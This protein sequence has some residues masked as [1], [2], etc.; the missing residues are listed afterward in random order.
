M[1]WPSI[2]A[3]VTA[4]AFVAL[5]FVLY[6]INGKEKGNLKLILEGLIGVGGNGGLLFIIDTYIP[7]ADDSVR[8]IGLACCFTSFLV[9]VALLLAIF[10]HIIK[11]KDGND[12]IRLRDIFLGQ[13]AFINKHYEQRSREIDNRLN[14]AELEQRETEI[15]R[16]ESELVQREKELASTRD[17]L[18]QELAKI[19]QLGSKKLRMKLPE[20]RNITLNQEYITTMPSHIEDIFTCIQDITHQTDEFLK[21]PRDS[22]D[23]SALKAYLLSVAT[24]ISVDLFGAQRSDGRVHFR[25][26]D[27][28]NNGYTKYVAVMGGTIATKGMTF[29]P[30]NTTNMIAR[31]YEC[32]RALIKSLN[33]AHHFES[34][35]YRIW[36]EYLTYT[37]TDLLY[38]DK[39]FLS[40]GISIKNV[41][42]FKK[43]L[44]FINYFQFEAFLQYNLER[45]NETVDI[46]SILYGGVI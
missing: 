30:Y 38:D 45:V 26:Y 21:K 22:I 23:E 33:S 31:S 7:I 10:A 42:R 2:F 24:H 46:A 5:F 13:Y 43:H 20:N 29:I 32:K 12:V 34:K 4:G 9:F 15:K 8:L 11:G 40:F 6:Y 18:A 17:Y 25:I 36:K 19:E 35:N 16:K 27:K 28:T 44:H 3:N 39:P 1:L 14:I 41:E 37:F